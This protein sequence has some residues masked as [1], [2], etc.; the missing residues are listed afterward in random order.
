MLN[1]SPAD[2][3]ECKV[4]F[5]RNAILPRL[6]DLAMRNAVLQPYRERVVSAARGRV[7]EIG[8]GSGL[9]LPLYRGE[10][11]EIY[12]LEP[13]PALR[14]MAQHQVARACRPVTFLSAGAQSIPLDDASV[15]TVVT[16][17]TMCTI[18]QA[19]LALAEMRRVL[20]PD[21]QLLFVE[22]GL[23]PDDA[24][25]KWQDRLTPVWKHVAGG[26]HLNRPIGRMI[27]SAGFQIAHINTGYARGP[28]PMTYLY[29][30]SARRSRQLP[31]A[32]PMA[33]LGH[34]R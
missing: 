6:C 5:Y 25:R 1:R 17:W 11:R 19:G 12:A 29:E 22:H 8:A 31:H 30:G 24:V 10:V 20:K 32:A 2:R 33:D 14:A 28:R 9:N 15:D 34:E 13:D 23:S 16:T 7:L 3:L 26:C 18:D 21:G 27:E 4:G